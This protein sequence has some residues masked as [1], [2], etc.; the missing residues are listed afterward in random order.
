M[1]IA[2]LINLTI[3]VAGVLLVAGIAILFIGCY[4]SPTWIPQGLGVGLLT[5]SFF[6]AAA[7]VL[8]VATTTGSFEA[9][10]TTQRDLTGLNAARRKMTD[11]RLSGKTL[12]NAS[13]GGADLS[14]VDLHDASLK[15]VMGVNANFRHANLVNVDF[16][17]SDLKGADFAGAD[18]QATK[19]GGGTSFGELNF[20]DTGTWKD[21]WKDVI[22]NAETCWPNQQFTDFITTHAEELNITKR[23]IVGSQYDESPPSYGRTCKPKEH[24]ILE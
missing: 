4:F 18:L 20:A 21:D 17:A 7:V 10:V 11:Y 5:G 1:H 23:E 14:G 2:T 19:F 3:V 24:A 22:V 6:A 8:Q 12:D 13:F 9:M 16:F 15:R